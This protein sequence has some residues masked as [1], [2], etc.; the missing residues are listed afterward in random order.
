MRGRES[1]SQGR[2]GILVGM[3]LGLVQIVLILVAVVLVAVLGMV[4]FVVVW[5]TK[6][7]DN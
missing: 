1:R 7:K 6:H 4:V 3:R 5:L 2:F